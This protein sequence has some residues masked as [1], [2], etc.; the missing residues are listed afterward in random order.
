MEHL[1]VTLHLKEIILVHNLDK[2]NNPL[3]LFI[4]YLFTLYS[5]SGNANTIPSNTLMQ[6]NM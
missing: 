4:I 1:K 5:F 6:V 2:Y 3:M